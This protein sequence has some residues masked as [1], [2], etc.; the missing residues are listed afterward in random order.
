M[1]MGK[2]IHRL[3]SSRG[4]TQEALAEALNVTP[5][6]VS[7]WE[8]GASMPDVQMLPEIAVYFGVTID[9]LFAMAPQQQ[10]ERIENRIY[11]QGIIDEAEERQLEQQLSAFAERPEYAG[12]AMLLLTKVITVPTTQGSRAQDTKKRRL[13]RTRKESSHP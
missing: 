3:R 6:T 12:Q 4:I 1:E 7:K 2:E 13:A 10:L 9:Q 8:R 5:Q 11:S